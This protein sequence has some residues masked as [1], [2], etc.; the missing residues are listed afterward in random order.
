MQEKY[1][2]CK[3]QETKI[4]CKNARAWRETSRPGACAEKMGRCGWGKG[5]E[6]RLGV[7]VGVA[8]HGRSALLLGGLVPLHGGDQ[9]EDDADDHPA[10]EH[11]AGGLAH[12]HGVVGHEE[13]DDRYPLYFT[14]LFG[15]STISADFLKN[16]NKPLVITDSVISVRLHFIV[17]FL[18]V[19][20]IVILDS[21]ERTIFEIIYKQRCVPCIFG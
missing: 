1:T 2:K 3:K 8:E 18:A 14:S 4:P 11:E 12:V 10:H 6:L 9:V 15:L 19:R 16:G 17:Q 21:I 5:R 13:Q 7:G 20:E